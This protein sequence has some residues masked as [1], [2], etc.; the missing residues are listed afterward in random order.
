MSETR[1][2]TKKV[3]V[4]D[5][6]LD[7]F[8]TY[9]MLISRLHHCRTR[10]SMLRYGYFS[11]GPVLA[12]FTWKRIKEWNVSMKPTKADSDAVSDKTLPVIIVVCFTCALWIGA[13]RAVR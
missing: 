2:S 9:G 8:G 4:L 13:Q 10:F 11:V 7:R 6:C 3:V 12:C 5:L 1:S